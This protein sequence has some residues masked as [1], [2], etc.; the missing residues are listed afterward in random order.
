MSVIV[1]CPKDGTIDTPARRARV[2]RVTDGLERVPGVKRGSEISLMSPRVKDV[3]SSDDSLEITPLAG[4]VPETDAEIAAFRERVRANSFLTS[5]FVT[6]DGRATSVLVD[7][8][9][10]KAAG[11]APGLAP[12]VE[13]I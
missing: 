5:L 13:S 2:K 6:D 8:D 12:R 10:F 3:H 9:D 11:G 7:F 1:Y 4:K